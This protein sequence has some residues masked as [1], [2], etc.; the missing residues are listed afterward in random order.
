[1]IIAMAID[2]G[3]FSRAYNDIHRSYEGLLRELV[4]KDA[5]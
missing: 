2:I 5:E 4:E 3:D 1:M